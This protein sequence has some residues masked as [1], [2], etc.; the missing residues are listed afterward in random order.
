M[1]SPLFIRFSVSPSGTALLTYV[2][3][4]G[5]IAQ[6]NASDPGTD[7]TGLQAWTTISPGRSAGCHAKLFKPTPP[8]AP[9]Y[10]FW[11]DIF[12]SS[13]LWLVAYGVSAIAEPVGIMVDVALTLG[14]ETA[15]LQDQA[16]ADFAW[17]NVYQGVRLDTECGVGS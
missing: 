9:A 6:I 10:T 17:R 15:T 2:S 14:S 5:A 7:W 4:S 12:K 16:T 13:V 11:S 3:L 8:S 1:S